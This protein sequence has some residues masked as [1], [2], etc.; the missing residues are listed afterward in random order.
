[1]GTCTFSYND[2][3]EAKCHQ[4]PF[5]YSACRLSRCRIVEADS[6]ILAQSAPRNLQPPSQPPQRTWQSKPPVSKGFTPRSNKGLN[7]YIC[8]SR[9][10]RNTQTRHARLTVLCTHTQHWLLCRCSTQGHMSKLPLPAKLK[11]C[12]DGTPRCQAY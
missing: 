4:E 2:Q 11:H 12:R 5:S 3:S 8:H 9:D 10:S 6:A 1:M 7:P